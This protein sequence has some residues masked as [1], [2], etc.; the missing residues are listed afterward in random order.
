[1]LHLR[2]GVVEVVEQAAP[3]LVRGRASE[4]L[5]VVFQGLPVDQ[6]DVPV[7]LFQALLQLVGDVAIHRSEDRLG[8]PES[9][10]EVLGLAGLNV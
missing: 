2:K 4:A 3:F 10:F 7:W 1:M 5:G 9:S 8:L 6:E